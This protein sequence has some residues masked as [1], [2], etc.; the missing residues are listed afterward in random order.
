[1]TNEEM[2]KLSD[3]E[4]TF[5]IAKIIHVC[6]GVEK[7]KDGSVFIATASINP[8]KVDYLNNWNDL[9]PLVI[10]HDIEFFRCSHFNNKSKEYQAF[11]ANPDISENEATNC[12]LERAYAECL[13][14]ILIAKGEIE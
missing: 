3:D 13:L 2:S 9:M 10:E 5:S 11:C 12:K 1:M 14:Q 4:L 8:I 7:R 6:G